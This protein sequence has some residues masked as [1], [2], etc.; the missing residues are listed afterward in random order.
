MGIIVHDADP[1]PLYE[2]TQ[3]QYDYF[4]LVLRSGGGGGDVPRS[5][6]PPVSPSCQVPVAHNGARKVRTNNTEFGPFLVRE[7][8]CGT[9]FVCA[10]TSTSP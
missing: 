9:E 5:L 6:E 3:E 2:V 8:R 7:L 1:P 4:V 10:T